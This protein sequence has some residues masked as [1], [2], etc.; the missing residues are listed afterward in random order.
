M[1]FRCGPSRSLLA[2]TDLGNGLALSALHG[3][4]WEGFPV[5]TTGRVFDVKRTGGG[6]TVRIGDEVKSCADIA[7]MVALLKTL[8]P[9]LGR[10]PGSPPA[11]GVP[12]AH[13]APGT[14]ARAR[15]PVASRRRFDDILSPGR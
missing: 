7:D 6:Y 5:S 9:P 10:D 11:A 4:F 15:P 14:R 2:R 1:M 13:A 8:L 12:V 3:K